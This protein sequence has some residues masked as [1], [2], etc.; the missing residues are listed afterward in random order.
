MLGV[1]HGMNTDKVKSLLKDREQIRS[2]R[3]Q[4]IGLLL[5]GMGFGVIM[6]FLLGVYVGLHW[7]H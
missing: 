1:H 7:L 5:M 6:G 4:E 3:K 2:Q